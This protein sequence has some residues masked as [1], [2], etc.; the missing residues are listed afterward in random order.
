MPENRFDTS[1]DKGYSSSY[2]PLPF[3]ELQAMAAN[4]QKQYDTAV[5]ETY[6]LNDMVNSI[7]VINDPNLGLSNVGLRKTI[8]AKYAPRVHE[9]SNRIVNG[10]DLSATRDLN[11]LKREIAND[12]LINEAKESYMN[13]KTYKD[14]ITKKAGKY[15]E[16]LD[17]YRNQNLFDDKSGLKPFRYAGLEDKLD[18]EKR[19]AES[20]DKIK[21]DTK[22]WDVESL[23]ADG[24]KIGKK[25]QQSGITSDKVMNLAKTKVSGVLNQT[26]EGQ[27]FVKKLRIMNTAS[28]FCLLESKSLS[29][30]GIRLL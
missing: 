6:K 10:G 16:V 8:D 24:I 28:G 27:Q 3:Q 9:I 5:D 15:D 25:G 7:P 17:T 26:P 13:Y 23:G 12:P 30:P 4:Q 1:I 2:I 20:M 11:N 21:E 22:G 18:I 14:D 29:V 19:F